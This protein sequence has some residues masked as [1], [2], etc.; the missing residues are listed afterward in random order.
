MP[1]LPLP[2]DITQES[3]AAPVSGSR[4]PQMAPLVLAQPDYEEIVQL[5]KRRLE[6]QIEANEI[7]SAYFKEKMARLKGT[8]FFKKPKKLS[9]L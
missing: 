8:I 1:T 5:K 2:S 4:M 7:V 9:T 3:Q 6:S